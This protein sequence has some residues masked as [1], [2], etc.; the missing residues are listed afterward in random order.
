MDR[1]FIVFLIVGGLSLGTVWAILSRPRESRSFSH[2]ESLPTRPGPNLAELRS[3]SSFPEDRLLSSSQELSDAINL[4]QP[5]APSSDL[6]LSLSP[7]PAPSVTPFFPKPQT[8]LKIEQRNVP[9]KTSKTSGGR[10]P[11]G[12]PSQARNA[13]PGQSFD[14][15][16]PAQQV[17][18]HIVAD[19]ETLPIIAQ[20]YYRDITLWTVIYQA[21]QDR[22]KSPELLPIGTELV[23]PPIPQDLQS[24]PFGAEA[25]RET[26]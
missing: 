2:M 16:E 22:L 15:L 17:V 6:L 24:T 8:L 19:G 1:G 26:P 14:R 18:R 23:I 13:R 21:N 9:E 12:V 3:P 20:R 5:P 11:S 25:T 7:P 4:T 10:L